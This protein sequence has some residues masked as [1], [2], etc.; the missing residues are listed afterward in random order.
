MKSF[1]QLIYFLI[2]VATAM[3]GYQIHHSVFWSVINFIFTPISWLVWLVCHDVNLT[4]IKQT[5]AFLFV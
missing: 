1:F 5:F 4:L 3:I 2:C